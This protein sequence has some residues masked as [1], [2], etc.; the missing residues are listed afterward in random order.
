MKRYSISLIIR[1]MKKDYNE[2]LPHL[3]QN[4]HH[5]NVYKQH[6]FERV[7]KKG[8]PPAWLRMQFDKTVVENSMEF[9]Q[10]TKNRTIL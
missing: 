4:S 6:V 3:G 7:W 9:L 2:V 5:K 10:K 1:E 8:N